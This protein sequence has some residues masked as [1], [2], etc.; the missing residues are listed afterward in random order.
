MRDFPAQLQTVSET[1]IECNLCL[2]ECGFLQ[3]YGNPKTIVQAFDPLRPDRTPAFECSLCGLCTAV[4]PVGIDPAGV[5]LE[6]RREAVRNGGGGQSGYGVISRYEKRGT[7]KRYTWYALPEGCDTVFFPG[8]N[9]PGTRPQRVMQLYEWLRAGGPSLGIVLDC[10]MKASHD[11]GRQDVFLAMLDELKGWLSEH[12]VR[13]ILVACPNCH[14]VFRKYGTG[15]AVKSV[16][17]VLSHRELPRAGTRAPGTMVI[18]D[19][20]A[21]R[22]ESSMQ[23]AVRDLV[24]KLGPD[25]GKVAHQREKTL[26]CG[27]GGAVHF[28][29]PEL[30]GKWRSLRKEEAAGRKIVSYC[31]GCVDFLGAAAP[32]VHILDLV[33][34]PETAISGKVKVSRS[35][36]TYWNRIR[37]KARF[38]KMLATAPVK[39]ERIFSA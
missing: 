22:F 32:A 5:F 19:P 9:L 13:T 16:Y 30:A 11:L 4:C 24:S 28:V 1:C 27:Q 25:V 31:G 3:R 8:C 10:C 39:R 6:M 21:V 36:F 14:A 7:S 26:C 37:L 38:K 18:H 34:D 12:G 2:K 20:C 33:F 35:P 29:A 17:E 15:F 23:D